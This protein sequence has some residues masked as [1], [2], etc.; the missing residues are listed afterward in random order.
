VIEYSGYGTAAPGSLLASELGQYTGAKNLLPD[1]S[2][3]VGALIAPTLGFATV[4]LQ[5]R[6]TGCSGGALRPLRSE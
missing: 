6:G 2:T 4:S 3:A 5:M 1:T